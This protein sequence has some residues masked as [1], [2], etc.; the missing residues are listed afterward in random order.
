MYFT[1]FDLQKIINMKKPLILAILI[2]LLYG[3]SKSNSLTDIDGN[4]YELVTIGNQTWFK[5]NLNVSKYRNGDIIPQ[6]TDQN[7]FANLTTGAWCYY[8]N[9]PAYEAIYGKLYNWHAV[10]DPRGLAPEGYHVPTNAEWSTLTTFLGGEQIAGG[11]MKE[12]GA[13]HWV[14]PNVA[15]TNGSGFTGLPGGKTGFNYVGSGGYW[16][17]STEYLETYFDGAWILSLSNDYTNATS[18]RYVKGF[19]LSVRCLKD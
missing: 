16:W 4:T 7:A 12:I 3:C 10:N 8:N 13:T 11:A 6:V 2:I 5:T 17:S 15:A 19:G 9:D 14:S 1:T 18:L